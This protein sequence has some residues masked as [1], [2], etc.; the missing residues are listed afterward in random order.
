ML[1]DVLKKTEIERLESL[2]MERE[3][4][5]Q[6]YKRD[7]IIYF[8]EI[9]KIGGIETWIYTLGKKYTFSVLYDKADDKQLER[10][11]EIGVETILNVGQEIEC[12]TL[13]EFLFNK[14]NIKRN[15]KAKRKLL[16]IH[17]IY[18]SRHEVGNI[19]EYDEVYA[20]SKVA[21]DSFEKVTGIKTKVLYNPIDIDKGD[22]PIILGVFSR[23]S[24]EKGKNRIMYIIEQLKSSNR[25]F[26]MLIFTDL[27][28]EEKDSRVV[29]MNP[30]LDT[31]GWMEKCDWIVNP[32]DTEAGSYTLQEAL[33]IGKPVVVTKLPILEEF[34]INESNA[35]I[36][37]F[38]MTNLDINKLWDIPKFKW[39][40]PISKEWED[41]MKK[42]VFRERNKEEVKKEEVKVEEPKK[43]TKK[44]AEK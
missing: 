14:R 19:P 21:A 22:K 35:M 23:L 41:I 28:F 1:A 20:V 44:K 9:H 10:L 8:S 3:K 30:T 18:E 42:R 13:I 7:T 37:D 2:R 29:F 17:C 27:P 4:Y 15:I 16:F 26:L 24:A 31:K 11:K 39:N 38:D 33:K 43:K 34:N 5:N 32:S 25:P 6:P 36:L 12:N 40:E